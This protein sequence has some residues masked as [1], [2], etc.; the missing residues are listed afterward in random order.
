M[1]GFVGLQHT[2]TPESYKQFKQRVE[3][4]ISIL[5]VIGEKSNYLQLQPRTKM[6]LGV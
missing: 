5:G 1:L 3:Q 2:K 6:Q 4:E